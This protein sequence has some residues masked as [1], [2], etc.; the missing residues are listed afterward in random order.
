MWLFSELGE[1]EEQ[2]GALGGERHRLGVSVGF[3]GPRRGSWGYRAI[4]GIWGLWERTA[5]IDEV[6]HF[7]VLPSS[8][9]LRFALSHSLES[10]LKSLSVESSDGTNPNRTLISRRRSGSTS[11]RRQRRYQVWK[12]DKQAASI[13]TVAADRVL[14]CSSKTAANLL[15][16]HGYGSPGPLRSCLARSFTGGGWWC[17]AL[18]A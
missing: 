17:G 8:S 6:I 7:N 16:A 1:I 2:Q 12:Q 3:R 13:G 9:F 15:I 4:W 14:S 10:G 5:G 11:H 18:K